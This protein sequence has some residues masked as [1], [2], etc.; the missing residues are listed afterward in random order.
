MLTAT[1]APVVS[2]PHTA[3]ASSPVP[4][5]AWIPLTTCEWRRNGPTVAGGWI[6]TAPLFRTAARR[7]LDCLAEDN[8]LPR[9]LKAGPDAPALVC[10]PN[11]SSIFL[12]DDGD[13]RPVTM[14]MLRAIVAELD[15]V[16]NS[17][18]HTI[19][20]AEE[21]LAWIRR[22]TTHLAS[23]GLRLGAH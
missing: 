14:A 2:L 13:E 1:P 5:M 16:V 19:D 11:E 8:A 15:R 20:E 12:A 7:V 17:K 4:G 23:H 3:S 22:I 18:H 6:G 10:M 9:G 21:A